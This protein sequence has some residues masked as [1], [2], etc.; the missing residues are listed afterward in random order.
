MQCIYYFFI[1]KI[2]V[3][4]YILLAVYEINQEIFKEF[5]PTN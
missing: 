5:M 3:Y 4:E 1:I 2:E